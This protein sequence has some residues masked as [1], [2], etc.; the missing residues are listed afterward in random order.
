MLDEP[1]GCGDGATGRA[2]A[3][4]PSR[5]GS[6]PRMGLGFI[7]FRFAV[8]LFLLRV[9]LFLFTCNT[10]MNTVP[11]SFLFRI[12]SAM[13][14]EKGKNKSWRLGKVTFLKMLDE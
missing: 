3:F 9:R 14:Q 4:Y 7:Q 8:N 5:L 6:N 12:I 13:Y 10:M 1:V 11:S 2:A